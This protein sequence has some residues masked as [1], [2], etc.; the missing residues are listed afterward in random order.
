MERV[1][2]RLSIA[3]GLAVATPAA[4]A[5]LDVIARGPDGA[6]VTDAV[7]T[8]HLVGRPTPI[9]RPE[10]GFAVDQSNIQFH[11]F[12]TIVPI[13]AAALKTVPRVTTRRGRR[14]PP[15]SG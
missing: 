1:L 14:R 11:S 15:G 10:G 13:G 9:P 6:P 5:D 12:V 3:L 7:V 8:V 2:S 4:A